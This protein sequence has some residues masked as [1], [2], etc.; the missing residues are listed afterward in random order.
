MTS[1]ELRKKLIEIARRDVGQRETSH[2]AGRAIKK[3]WPATSY[4]EGYS[5]RAPYCAAAMAYWVQQWLKDP[6]VAQAFGKTPAQ[7]E[8][9]RCKSAAA[10]AWLDWAKRRNLPILSNASTTVL[11]TADIMVFSMSHIG[12][13]VTDKGSQVTTIEANT[14]SSGSREGDGIYQKVRQ[15]SLARAFIRLLP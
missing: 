10:F 3:F 12:L 9:W 14:G 1:L 13:V 8:T 7:L 4:P 11:R 15:R 5:L 6:D 2:N